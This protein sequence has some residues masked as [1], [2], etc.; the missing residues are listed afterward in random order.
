MVCV[1]VGISPN[2]TVSLMY[3]DATIIPQ[4]GTTAYSNGEAQ[5]TITYYIANR[6][7]VQGVLIY[8]QSIMYTTAL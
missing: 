4:N 6:S 5:I 2:M 8:R 3:S 7:R 1:D